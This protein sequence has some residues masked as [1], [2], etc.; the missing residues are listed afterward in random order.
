MENSQ[1]KELIEKYNV[2]VDVN[3][4][5]DEFTKQK[6][7][8]MSI[9]QVN[10]LLVKICVA[11][12]M[13]EPIYDRLA[14]ILI[15]EHIKGMNER[16]GLHTYVDKINYIDK[17]I[18]GYLD[19]LFVKF[20]NENA[21]LLNNLSDYYNEPIHIPHYLTY[22]GCMTLNGAYCI[23]VKND[24]GIKEQIESP[25]DVFLRC[26]I[27]VNFGQRSVAD[28]KRIEQNMKY[29]CQGKFT[30]ATPTLF[31]AGTNVKQMSSCY[32][33]T[34]DD[35]IEGIYKTLTDTA[36][37][38]KTCGGIGFACT[39]VRGSG[40]I[41]N[42]SNGESSGI[43]PMLK[44]YN[45][46]AVYV[47]Q[48]GR[49]TKRKGAFAAFLEPWHCDVKEFIEL[50][51]NT[52]HESKRARDLNLGLWIPDL[53]MKQLELE[54][55]TGEKK[56]QL[57][58]LAR[59]EGR[60]EGWWLMCP[61][62]CPGLV[63]AY[64][65]EFEKLYLNYVR[66]G[67]Y[68]EK[69]T[70]LEIMKFV[71]D[72]IADAGEPYMLFKDTVNL[73]SNQSNIGTVKSSNLCC[74]IMEVADTDKHAVCNLA[75][76]AVNRFYDRDTKVYDVDEL[77]KVAYHVC[78]NLN[79][80][81]DDNLYPTQEALYSNKNARPVGIGVQG[82]ADLLMDMG[83]P[84]ESQDAID[85]EAMVAE[86]I[87][88]GAICCS[89]DLAEERGTYPAY[90]GSP[91]SKGLFQFDMG[92]KDVKLR[93]DWEPIKERAHRFGFYNSQL[94]AYMPT[95]ST[96]QILG[97]NECFEPITSNLYKRETSSGSFTIINKHL[98][99]DLHDLGLWNE[100]MNNTIMNNHGSIQNI[101]T[102]PNNIKEIYKTVWEIKQKAIMDHAI[103]RAPFIDQ[104]QSM[105]LHFPKIEMNKLL[106]ALFYAWKGGLKTASY[107]TRSQPADTQSN[108][109]FFVGAGEVCES[110]SA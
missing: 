106:S 69:T 77:I 99:R 52:G 64:G 17:H 107:Y 34:I 89:I 65:D 103:A 46:T 32:L 23:T 93:L 85:T 70:A 54:I 44:V 73:K 4:I 22:F 38:S 92:Y 55:A 47:N 62:E 82:V 6:V 86:A 84:Y 88:Y 12:A 81:I 60:E 67:R 48:G 25:T 80:V 90:N 26:S 72:T 33:L 61:Y 5:I 110:C 53:F 15:F 40:T 13:I 96:S 2:A 8:N 87:Y 21:T 43:V 94:T 71:R 42:S 16:K 58:D 100:D 19:P 101:P 20:V 66:E 49:G 3:Y 91:F 11:R 37:I 41:I 30:H 27:G 51:L 74:E 108:T 56:E 14:V 76:I 7:P 29:N 9:E 1:F 109:A 97:N 18:S 98:I 105:N 31:N 104:S 10:T 59:A 68:K 24:L 35:S 79:N 39:Q 50:R 75:S 83:I 95:A 45:D 36:R 28:L 102:I 78:Y 63:N 57:L